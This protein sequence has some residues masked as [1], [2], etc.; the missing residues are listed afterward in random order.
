MN[1][2]AQELRLL[3]SIRDVSRET[4]QRL[5]MF[6]ELLGNW[7]RKTNLVSPATLP[8]FWSRHVADSLQCL[9]LKPDARRW[10]DLGS[11]GGFPAIPIA[12]ANREQQSVEHHLVESIHKKCAFLREAIRITGARGAVHCERIES[13]AERLAKTAGES[14]VITARALAALPVL[15]DL[16]EPL[17]GAGGVALF[18]KGREFETELRECD[19]LWKFDL[20]VHPSRVEADSVVLEI[21][22]ASRLSAE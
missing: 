13:A 15:L 16:A 6:Q 4:I 20:I 8:Q 18:H 1:P 10:I 14:A 3:E 21:S 7:Q 9:A 19:G 11:G 22:A 5:G 17:M 2:T 12:I